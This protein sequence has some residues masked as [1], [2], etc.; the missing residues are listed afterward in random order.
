MT[1][2]NVDIVIDCA[3][4]ERLAEFWSEA[5]GYAKLGFFD[6]CFLL[7]AKVREHPPVILPRVPES[8]V[9][10]TRIHFDLR[11]DD[12]EGEA[13]RLEA[14][15]AQ[16]IDIGQ[17]P[18]PGWIAMADPDGNEFCVC[19]GI[20]LSPTVRRV[21]RSPPVPGE[22]WGSFGVLHFSVG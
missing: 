2:P 3:D 15:G 21:R 4:P 19:P 16:R 9:G 11:V 12:I 5:L 13:R 6:P 18:D 1:D 8:K 14:L 22:Q 10:K 20:P 17:G 7:V